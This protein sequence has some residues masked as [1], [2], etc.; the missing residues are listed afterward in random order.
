MNKKN[1]VKI[2]LQEG[3]TFR[4]FIDSLPVLIYAFHADKYIYVNPAFE[5]AL[6]YTSQELLQM[7]FWDVVH[8]EYKEFIRKRGQ[9]RLRGEQ[10]PSHYPIKAVKKNGEIMWADVFFN[11]TQVAGEIVSIVGAYDITETKRLKEEL[12]LRVAERTVE[13]TKANHELNV[14]NQN[15]NHIVKNMTDGV[16]LVS[17]MGE[18]EVLNPASKKTWG[19][20][21]EDLPLIKEKFFNDENKHYEL[22][23]N[24]NIA[25]QDEEIIIDTANNSTRF[26]ASGTPIFNENN[27]VDTA[28]IIIKPIEDIHR[29]VN[30]FSGATAKF[31]FA[32]IITKNPKM[33]EVISI[34]QS[35]AKT[36][37]IIMI[38]GESGTG[39]E[40][41]AQ[42]IHNESYRASGP[43]VALNCGAIP[44][45]LIASELFGYAEGA[46]TGAKRGGNPGKFELA[47]GGT[48]FLDEI[49]DMPHE[50]QV[51]LLRVIQE[52]NITRIGG[53][54]VIPVD[55]RIICATNKDLLA[56]I[57]KGNFRQDLYYRLNVVSIRIPPLRERREDIPLLFQYFINKTDTNY[58]IDSQVSLLLD[59]LI[60]SYAWPGNVREIQNIVE[61]MLS[62]PPDYNKDNI[63][64]Y[65]DIIGHNKFR[66]NKLDITLHEAYKIKKHDI[67]QDEKEKIIR[68]LKEHKGNITQV[69]KE[70]EI[71]RSTLYRKMKK[72]K[73]DPTEL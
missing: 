73:I 69:A 7:N 71:A 61:R 44:R 22:L 25:F 1:D 58:N 24:D 16:V 11:I 56:E 68:L 38:K 49:G 46:F 47:S 70:M 53:H 31:T 4:K 20:L 23:F 60:T 50:Q 19:N 45:E 62:L 59:N 6:G 43:F 21:L 28:L 40:L 55:V 65:I 32:N 37:S 35:V 30:R 67:K 66:E 52:K 17:K 26:L 3:S 18:M 33:L 42:A 29:L 34:A 64:P 48:L 13:L 51:A 54:H 39:K 9:A 57:E 15:L 14:L 41:F 27:Q 12:E 5:K 8:P 10:V 72:Y 36:D 2:S 63:L